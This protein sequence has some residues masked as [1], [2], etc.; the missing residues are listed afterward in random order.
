MVI[1]F[2]TDLLKGLQL[3]LLIFVVIG[4]ICRIRE[5]LW[6]RFD[7]LLLGCF[8][9]YV[10]LSSFQ[11]WLFYGILKTSSRYV[12]I[13]L[14]LYLPFA[15]GGLVNSWNMLKKYKMLRYA[16]MAAVGVYAL[17]NIYNIYSPLIKDNTSRRHRFERQMTLRAAGWIKNDWSDRKCEAITIQKCD[18][19]QS[20]RRPLVASEL[21]RIGYLAGGQSFTGYLQSHGMQPDYIV[22]DDDLPSG[23]RIIHTITLER[24]TFYI[25]ERID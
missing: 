10:I 15:A 8:V 24:R 7:S 13:A 3:P 12:L 16:A 22:G 14:P 5:H 17:I 19:Y 25:A 1:E 6:S 2:L 23:F 11:I 9:L 21:E 20:G 4:I 18:L